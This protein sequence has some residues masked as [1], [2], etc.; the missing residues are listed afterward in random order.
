MSCE[1]RQVALFLTAWNDIDKEANKTTN[2]P[3]SVDDA[4]LVCSQ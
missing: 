4:A 2:V 3:H 1:M